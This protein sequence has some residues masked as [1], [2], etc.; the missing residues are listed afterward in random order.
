LPRPRKSHVCH[1][2]V[3]R[4]MDLEDYSVETMA[5]LF[6]RDINQHGRYDYFSYEGQR[7]LF[8]LFLVD[9]TIKAYK[10]IRRRAKHGEVQEVV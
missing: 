10:P 1:R 9:V 6:D 3:Y 5:K 8:D 2:F 4:D 7:N